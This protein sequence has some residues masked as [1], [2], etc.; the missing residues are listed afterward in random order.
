[1]VSTTELFVGHESSS[2]SAVLPLPGAHPGQGPLM[3]EKSPGQWE[4]SEDLGL[5]YPPDASF[6][7]VES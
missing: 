6:S 7:S 3:G 5:S 1:M 2:P 4:G